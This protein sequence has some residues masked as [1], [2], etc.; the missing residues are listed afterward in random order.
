MSIM[1]M[2]YSEGW[3]T[4]DVDL[5]LYGQNP[6]SWVTLIVGFGSLVTI[7]IFG[8]G[9]LY[10]VLI[11][12]IKTKHKA[13]IELQDYKNKL[14][15]LV[16]ERTLELTHANQELTKTM[17]QLKESQAKLIET[18]KMA[19][20]GTLTAGVS[21]EINNPLNFIHG[22]Y[23]GLKKY[24]ET[25]EENNSKDVDLLMQGLKTGL[26]RATAIVKSLNQFNR[27]NS[28]MDETCDIHNILENCLLILSNQFKRQ[29]VI[30]RQYSESPIIVK[31]NVG[32]L[33]QVFINLLSNSIHAIENEGEI[34]LCTATEKDEAVIKITDNGKGIEDQIMT[35]IMDPFFTTKDPGQGTGLGLTISYNIIKDHEGS[36]NV[37]SQLEKGTDVI[38]KLPIRAN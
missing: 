7:I 20:L 29:I 32:K 11:H 3:L 13:F 14:E 6:I 22:S 9:Y 35:R 23:L 10:E 18:E 31:G 4:T 38:I 30:N 27:T 24:L 16:E 28:S 12:L 21:H 36:I 15:S 5:N 37:I 17:V 19:S 26:D 1:A 25:R 33:H 2:G 8:I 34:T